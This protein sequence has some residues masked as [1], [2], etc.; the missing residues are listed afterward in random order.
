MQPAGP[1][2]IHHMDYGPG[3]A[4]PHTTHQL[5]SRSSAG[6]AP[7][8]PGYHVSERSTEALSSDIPRVFY[9]SSSRV[10]SRGC[11]GGYERTHLRGRAGSAHRSGIGV[12]WV[13]NHVPLRHMHG[14]RYTQQ[15]PNLAL[16]MLQT[17]LAALLLLPLPTSNMRHAPWPRGEQRVGS[18][19]RVSP[20]SQ[21]SQQPRPSHA[22][23]KHFSSAPPQAPSPTPAANSPA[24]LPPAARCPTART[25]ASCTLGASRHLRERGHGQVLH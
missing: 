7:G 25:T 16:G 4:R 17:A 22:R 9:R 18:T 8:E 11:Q 14:T 24:P 3:G 15:P 21:A 6:A 13:A 23:S 12:A 1:R 19:H 20:T 2:P 10:L 5:C